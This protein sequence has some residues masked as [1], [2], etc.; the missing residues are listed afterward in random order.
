VPRTLGMTDVRS[1]PA[2]PS[3]PLTVRPPPHSAGGLPPER[4]DSRHPS[5]GH[6]R[7]DHASPAPGHLLGDRRR[8]RRGRRVQSLRAGS[9][10][11][12]GG[13]VGVHSGR[14]R[15]TRRG[16][17]TASSAPAATARTRRDPPSARACSRRSGP[18][19][20]CRRGRNSSRSWPVSAPTKGCR[21]P[22]RW[23]SIRRTSPGCTTTSRVGARGAITAVVR[24]GGKARDLGRR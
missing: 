4:A 10:G 24:P 2:C 16:S 8:A 15:S 21:R 1:A 18:T 3:D 7:R 20:R 14:D 23:G 17:S 11:A 12:G 13:A 9:A 5:Q 19:A 22:R 6:D